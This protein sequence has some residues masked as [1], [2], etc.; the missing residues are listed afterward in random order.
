MNEMIHRMK[1]FFLYPL[2]ENLLTQGF[3]F[4]YKWWINTITSF[5]RH[6]VC[7]ILF[8]SFVFGNWIFS[9][10]LHWAMGPYMGHCSFVLLLGGYKFVPQ[11]F[12]QDER[13]VPEVYGSLL[14]AFTART[15]CLFGPAQLHYK[16]HV[17]VHYAQEGLTA[18]GWNFNKC[19]S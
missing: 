2:L 6:N 3:S 7:K 16:V 19:V 15:R 9:I 12:V 11:G 5:W 14:P 18:P 1:M 13:V 4:Q 17:L 10:T 8:C